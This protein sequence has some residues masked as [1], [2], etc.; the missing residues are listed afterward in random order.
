MGKI[1]FQGMHPDAQTE[2]RRLADEVD[3]HHPDG[4]D[5]RH[6][7]TLTALADVE[8]GRVIEDEAMEAWADSLGTDRELPVPKPL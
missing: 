6:R 3:L 8:A 1:D 4:A 7:R 5:R 2:A